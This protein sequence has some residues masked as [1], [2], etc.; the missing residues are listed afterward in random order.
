MQH[1]WKTKIFSILLLACFS[2]GFS[3]PV[4]HSLTLTPDQSQPSSW[5]E[6]FH[7]DKGTMTMEIQNDGPSPVYYYVFTYCDHLEC[8]TIAEGKVPPGTKK[9]QKIVHDEGKF[10][11][12]LDQAPDENARYSHATGTI[13][14]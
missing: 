8:P 3:F 11:F 13:R 7:L 14:Q 2:V 9:I 1:L 4:E 6:W 12:K 10:M 5:T